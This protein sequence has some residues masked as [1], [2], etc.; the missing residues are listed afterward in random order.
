[1]V[2]GSNYHGGSN[3]VDGGSLYID[4]G[5]VTLIGGNKIVGSYGHVF[6]G[7]ALIV[8]DGT[9]TCGV[10]Y[11]DNIL[12]GIEPTIEAKIN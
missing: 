7:K 9:L 12:K 4:G 11:L 3:A 10:G 6:K 2:G 5:H 8:T 1:M